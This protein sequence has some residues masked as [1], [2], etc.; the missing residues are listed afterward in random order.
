MTSF[1]ISV[2]IPCF[3]EP[4]KLSRILSSLAEQEYKN[5]EVIVS[6][7]A[8]ITPLQT[9]ALSFSDRIQVFYHRNQVNSG[10][11]ATRNRGIEMAT[12]DIYFFL[13][14]DQILEPSSLAELAKHYDANPNQTV[15]ANVALWP[16]IAAG[17]NYC[18]YYNSRFLGQR[19][20]N[21]LAKMDL[22]NL[23]PKFFAT[24][25]IAVPARVVQ[26]LNGFSEE[27]KAYGCE[28]E[29]FGARLHDL[30]VPLRWSLTVPVYDADENLSL[31]RSCER[32][33]DYARFSAPLLMKLHPHYR[34]Q[35][36]FSLF[37]RPLSELS[38]SLKVMR[39]ALLWVLQPALALGV[40]TWLQK[41]DRASVSPPAQFYQL[42]L[43]GFYLQGYRMRAQK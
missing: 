32:M 6:D 29:E 18:K 23:P 41:R 11:A 34:N 38:T 43:L 27:F 31:K 1:R 4:E 26:E 9:T 42:A 39:F 24:G 12:G 20:S 2:I 8:S 17:S 21:E 35:S 36:A 30:G 37:E 28:D 13:D 40:V 16:V 25:S 14:V 22:A 19:S 7:D 10:R 33:I 3:A 5:F 15:R